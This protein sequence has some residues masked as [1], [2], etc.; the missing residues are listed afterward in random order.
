MGW[1]AGCNRVIGED[2]TLLLGPKGSGRDWS[3]TERNL[4]RVS[5]GHVPPA[6]GGGQGQGNK[7]ARARSGLTRSPKMYQDLATG[8]LLRLLG[9]CL[10]D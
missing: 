2:I 4:K 3:G 9:F 10:G 6:E 8:W 5:K 1:C 7:P